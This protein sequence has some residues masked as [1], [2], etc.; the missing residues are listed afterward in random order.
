M[1]PQNFSVGAD[2][3][4]GDVDADHGGDGNVSLLVA[5]CSLL[6]PP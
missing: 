4:S 1:L 3:D 2:D 5:C 6:N